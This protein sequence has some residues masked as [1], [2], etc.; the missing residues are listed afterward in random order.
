MELAVSGNRRELWEWE[1]EECRLLKQ[2]VVALKAT[3]G[4]KYTQSFIASEMGL[5]QGYLNNYLTGRRAITIDIAIKIHAATG[6]S[7]A[8]FSSRL[9]KEIASMA[10]AVPHV[11]P[12][13]LTQALPNP[14]ALPV[15]RF[16]TEAVA[17]GQLDVSDLDIIHKLA[18]HLVVAKVA[19][20]SGA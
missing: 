7:I 1:L 17:E 2:A 14:T 18:Q 19:E 9:A 16:I 8:S 20:A 5:T 10:A 12:E 6:I 13:P 4:R 3:R 11:K 15:T